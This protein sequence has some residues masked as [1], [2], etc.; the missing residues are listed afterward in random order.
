LPVLIFTFL[1]SPLAAQTGPTTEAEPLWSIQVQVSGVLANPLGQLALQKFAE[2]EP[3]A[4]SKVNESVEALG[5]DPRT[6]IKT[7]LITGDGFGPG[8][9]VVQGEL[10]QTIGNL[11]GWILAAPGYQ[12]EDLD[13][14]TLLHSFVIDEGDGQQR[15]WC[16]MPRSDATGAFRVIAAFDKATVLSLAKTVRAGQAQQF[17]AIPNDLVTLQ[18]TDLSAAPLDIDDEDPGAAVIKTISGVAFKLASIE[19]ELKA[20]LNLKA[21][22]PVK[23]KQLSQLLQGLKAAVQ[24]AKG[25]IQEDEALQVIEMLETV[26]VLHAEG[27]DEVTA[28]FAA[29]VSL[30]EQ[31]IN[32]L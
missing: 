21:S 14:D 17:A 19:N 13:S 5:F 18:F 30:I 23:A 9:V 20:T 28:E 8:D 24:L 16:A 10:G 6:E 27:A 15:L 12:S 32:A 26:Q 29:P 1:I 22:S 7:L 11:E 25:E 4:F 3:E 2:E 31:L